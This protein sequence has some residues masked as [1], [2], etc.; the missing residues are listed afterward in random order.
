[1]DRL[2]R[3]L[4]EVRT[5]LTSTASKAKTFSTST[6]SAQDRPVVE[7][8]LKELAASLHHTRHMLDHTMNAAMTT[9]L[10]LSA[11]VPLDAQPHEFVNPDGVTLM[12]V[13]VADRS[14][15]D[16]SCHMPLR[17]HA[18]SPDRAGG[19]VSRGSSRELRSRPSSRQGLIGGSKRSQLLARKSTRHG[20]RSS[21]RPSTVGADRGSLHTSFSLGRRNGSQSWR[22]RGSATGSGHNR[23][24]ASALRL[25]T[26][27]TFPEQA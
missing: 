22:K 7:H 23:G 17:K 18:A 11:G 10:N 26:L 24:P 3:Q 9:R 14:G 4:K 25:Q 27:P 21:G 1:M 16:V 8:L 15:R 20:N 6:L 5:E 12:Q 19:T 2:A 13:G